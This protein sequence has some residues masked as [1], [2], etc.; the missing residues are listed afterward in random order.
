MSQF[1]TFGGRGHTGCN[2]CYFFEG[3]PFNQ[4]SQNFKDDNV[5]IHSHFIYCI[6]LLDL[7]S[8]RSSPDL[9]KM[10]KIQAH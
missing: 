6:E 2:I 4:I 8:I 1:V 7:Q 10:I 3:I 9:T 5:K